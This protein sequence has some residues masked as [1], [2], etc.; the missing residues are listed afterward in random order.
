MSACLSAVAASQPDSSKC[1][2]FGAYRS[3]LKRSLAAFWHRLERLVGRYFFGKVKACHGHAFTL[4][5]S[6]CLFSLYS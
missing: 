5:E 2:V 3:T 4:I 6:V 1:P